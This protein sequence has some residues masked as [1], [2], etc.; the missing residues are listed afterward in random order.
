MD[1]PRA[2]RVKDLVLNNGSGGL[3]NRDLPANIAPNE[4]TEL[5]NIYTDEG[6]YPGKSMPGAEVIQYAPIDPT[7]YVPD[8]NT[9]AHYALDELAFGNAMIDDSGNGYNLTQASIAND[10]APSATGLFPI[11][12]GLGRSGLIQDDVIT[13]NGTCWNYNFGVGSSPL[14]NFAALTIRGWIKIPESFTG[15]P[16]QLT[17]LGFAI[18]PFSNSGATLF[19]TSQTE[20]AAFSGL[21]CNGFNLYRDWDA[22]AGKNASDPYLILT[23]R[24][25]GIAG[26]VT[27]L[28]SKFLPTNKMLEVKVT[29]DSVTATASL[30]V[31]GSLHDTQTVNGGGV[32]DD[33]LAKYFTALG[34]ETQASGVFGTV[35]KTCAGVVID[36]WEIS[37][38]IRTGFNFKRPRARWKEFNKSDGT[39]QLIGPAGDG[40]Y[41]TIGDGNYTRLA[42]GLNEVNNWDMWQL[43]DIM[44]LC[45]G[46]DPPVAWDGTRL[47]SWFKGTAPLV[48]TNAASGGAPAA[49]V[50]YYAYTYVYGNEETA[51]YII[52]VGFTG[53]GQNINIDNI[54]SRHFN[55]SAIRIYRTKAGG[56]TLYLLREIDNDDTTIVM[57]PMNGLFVN[58]STPLLDEGADGVVDATLGTGAYTEMRADVLDALS[59]NPKYLVENFDRLFP[60]GMDDAPYQLD[61]TEPGLPD[62]I[63]PTSFATAHGNKVITAVS[64]AQGEVHAH[65]G[66]GGVTML[67]GNGPASWTEF[68][69]LHPSIGCTDHF[70]IEYRTIAKGGKDETDRTILVFPGPDGFYGY[71][72]YEFYRIDDIIKKTFNGLAYRNSTRLVWLTST[73]AQWESEA[74]QGGSASINVDAGPYL[75]DGLSE[76]PG[77]LRIVN[78]LEYIG[79]WHKSAGFIPTGVAGNQ[80]IAMCPVKVADVIV[81]GYFIFAVSADS[82]LYLTTD[83]WQTASIIPGATLGAVAGMTGTATDYRIIEITYAYIGG[84]DK[85]F[86]ATSNTS[87]SGYWALWNQTAGIWENSATVLGGPYFW[88]ADVPWKFSSTAIGTFS[89]PNAPSNNDQLKSFYTVGNGGPV[90]TLSTSG[91]PVSYTGTAFGLH[92][93]KNFYLN[94]P[95]TI[96]ESSGLLNVFAQNSISSDLAVFGTYNGSTGFNQRSLTSSPGVLALVTG[97]YSLS[98]DGAFVNQTVVGFGGPN[99]WRVNFSP[100]FT[101]NFTKRETALWQGGT[102]RPQSIWDATNSKL[103]FVGSG[104]EDASGNRTSTIY[105]LTAAGAVANMFGAVKS[106][107][108]MASDGANIWYTLQ[109]NNINN[110]VAYQGFNTDLWKLVQATSVSTKITTVDFTTRRNVLP[111]RLSWNANTS[112]LLAIGQSMVSG[113]QYDNWTY[114]GFI[115]QLST[116]DG[117][118]VPLKSI[119]SNGASGAF[120][121]EVVYQ[122]DAP[123]SHFVV[124]QGLQ[125]GFAESVYEVGKNMAAI[126]SPATVSTDVSVY[127]STGLDDFTLGVRSQAIFVSWSNVAGNYL[128]SDRFYWSATRDVNGGTTVTDAKPVQLGVPGNWI[129]KGEYVSLLNNLGGFSAFDSF[130]TDFSGSVAFSMANGSAAAIPFSAANFIPITPNQKITLNGNPVAAWAQ[131]KV[132]M[133]WNY[134]LG[135]P[136]AGNI[137]PYVRFVNVSYFI[138]NADIPRILAIHHNGRT[139]WSVAHAGQQTNDLEIV[140]MKNNRWTTAPNRHIVTYALFRGDLVAFEDYT[141]I[142]M[143]TGT[144]WQG[145]QIV[146]KA[147][148]GYLMNDAE[149]K[150]IRQILASLMSYTNSNFP[151][152]PGWIKVTPI[153]AGVPLTDAAWFIPI[154]ATAGDPAPVQTKGEMVSFTQGWARAFAFMIETSDDFTGDHVPDVNQTEQIMALLVKMRV[155]PPRS[156][157]PVA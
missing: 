84:A 57:P 73:Q 157:L 78:Q 43:G 86:C 30:Y 71:E 70:G 112:K 106:Y 55:C 13:S 130:A 61:W 26:T 148:T 134:T 136:D 142:R 119:A 7:P 88:Q 74:A 95:Q 115:S 41:M 64:R 36:E 128:W 35:V 10:R 113:A 5:E 156:I 123:Y 87:E 67:R 31:Q 45:N 117:S 79:L 125:T 100:G 107:I 16:V 90:P 33:S 93:G 22:V 32:V 139:R 20:P 83:N 59:P 1:D 77:E 58:G 51:P 50:Y 8:A 12:A 129:V 60:A 65:K 4:F 21:I 46:I 102:F 24:T 25:K 63:L 137:A 53:T 3:N 9:I 149:D 92:A 97:F 80:V 23:L 118:F 151:T 146:T 153:A 85:Y 19:G 56:S 154:T 28:R 89:I 147:V 66:L 69:N 38:V 152:K 98:D 108:A 76:T 99:T 62:I 49:G 52:P 54:L 103:F 17:R 116:T 121:L 104:A 91:P 6:G 40:L 101:V 96:S 2:T 29:Y 75:P 127:Q 47:V 34:S 44:Y 109:N 144:N 141:L 105:S 143:E 48:I 72:G 110:G 14:D 114:E 145:N 11:G 120:P 42:T 15:A 155:S 94:H 82:N 81:E 126:V 18:T 150:Y 27:T 39:V 138:G 140:Y 135:G 37:N 122:T 111:L 132:N 133:T 131:F 68:E 124:I